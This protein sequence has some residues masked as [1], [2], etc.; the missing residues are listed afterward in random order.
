MSQTKCIRCEKEGVR[1]TRFEGWY[2]KY[3]YELDDGFQADESASPEYQE[4]LES[5]GF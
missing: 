5:R 2:C 1:Y 4:Y 3:H